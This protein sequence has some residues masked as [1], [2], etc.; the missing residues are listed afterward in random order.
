M[1]NYFPKNF[2]WGGSISANQAEGAWN[3]DGKGISVADLA[4]FQ[5]NETDYHKQWLV[6]RADIKSG[7]QTHDTTFYPKRHGN[8]FY[9]HYE[10][11]IE[12]FAEMG[13]KTLRLSIAWSRIFPK[14]DEEK[15]NKS[16]IAFYNNVFKTLKKYNIEP[17]VTLSH[18]E[19]PLNL[20]LKYGGWY[21]RKLIKFFLNYSKNVFTEYKQ[22]V[23]YWITFNEIDSIFR[24]PF[25]TAGIIE[26]DY[27]PQKLEEVIYQALHHQFIASALSTKMLKEII[28]NGQMG[29]MITRSLDY[30]ETCNPDDVLLAQKL[31]RNNYLYS[32]VQA[33]GKYPS[34]IFNEWQKKNI[35]VD[36]EKDDLDILQNNTVDFISFSYYMSLVS[37]IND[38]NKEKVGG[39]FITG[40]K[41]KYLK[42]SD[43]GWQ[44]DPKGF[45][46]ALI[47]L[48]D[49]YQM[50]L[51]CVENGL[52]AK[53]TVNEDG[54]INDEYRIN[55]LKK[56]IEQ[57]NL[58]IRDG[59]KLIG[60]T[61]WGCID[62]VSADTSQ[63]S[64]RYGFIYVDLDDYGNGTYSRKN[65][66]SFYWYKNVISSNGEQL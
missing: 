26:E 61:P 35:N 48:Y 43:W 49:R 30:P 36:M 58:A 19:M 3:E 11:D 45:R 34:Y 9:H 25:T 14:G 65:K 15:P 37:S 64:K 4:K 6:T 50:P 44:I 21:N 41:N 8:D 38:N 51:W 57:M 63:M 23:K 27:P 13:F 24:H 60:Y 28:P 39:N 29:C 10:E 7:V 18:Y 5:P 22:Y 62:L 59:V 33:R 16:G 66:K 56:H 40:I 54:S 2:M 46:I 1:E 32:D 52:G 17:L 55:Y 42:T 47:G 12:K 31:N 20:V 53:D